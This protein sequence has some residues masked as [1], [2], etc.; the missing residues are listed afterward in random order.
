[1]V[2]NTPMSR[3]LFVIAIQM[4]MQNFLAQRS[5]YP[6]GTQRPKD[7]HLWFYFGRDVLDHNRTK[8]GGIRFL[9]YFGSAKSGMHLG[10]GN[11][12]TFS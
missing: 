2:L 9:T 10:S 7:L 4:T 3:K 6:A 8:I 5:K 11:I 1:M 12:E